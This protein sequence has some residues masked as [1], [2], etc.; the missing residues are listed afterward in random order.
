[1]K[2]IFLKDQYNIFDENHYF[3]SII[4]NDNNAKYF[5]IITNKIFLLKRK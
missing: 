3:Y 4:Q 1:M 2:L 5:G